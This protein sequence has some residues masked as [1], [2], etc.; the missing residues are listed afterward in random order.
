MGIT[1]PIC[2]SQT[3]HRDACSQGHWIAAIGQLPVTVKGPVGCNQFI[4]ASLTDPPWGQALTA[5]NDPSAHQ[6]VVALS[7]EG[8]ETEAEGPVMAFAMYALPAIAGLVQV[9]SPAVNASVRSLLLLIVPILLVLVLG[10]S[11]TIAC[12]CIW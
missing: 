10:N 6:R 9:T 12:M 5:V 4:V 2:A 1:E 8:K 11:D 7:L 3:L